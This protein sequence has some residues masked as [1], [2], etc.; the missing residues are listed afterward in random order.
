[1]SRLLGATIALETFIGVACTQGGS[2]TVQ[3]PSEHGEQAPL[4]TRTPLVQACTPQKLD[5]ECGLVK[6]Y[7]S[8]SMAPVF[9]FLDCPEEDLRFTATPFP[10]NMSGMEN[11]GTFVR[12]QPAG[13]NGVYVD[14]LDW[15]EQGSTTR[16]SALCVKDDSTGKPFDEL[17]F[18]DRWKSK[19]H[20]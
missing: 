1:M 16:V 14:W 7:V 11:P 2:T 19:Q 3:A 15:Q 10:A 20:L 12:T 17:D 8:H 18:C 13:V 5:E 6:D 4:T 9:D